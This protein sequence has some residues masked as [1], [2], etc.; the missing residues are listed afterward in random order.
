MALTGA[1]ANG[2]SG[3]FLLARGRADGLARV[4]RDSAP[5]VGVER[6]AI[7]SFWAVA[8]SAPALVGMRLID[9]TASGTPAQPLH[10]L[11][12]DLLVFV[13]GWTGY[14][15]LSRAVVER[16]G[17]ARRWAGYLTVWNWCNVVQ[18]VLLLVGSLPV[19]FHAPEPVSQAAALVVLGWALWLEW[20]ATRL[21]L[22]LSGAAAA[23]L[24]MLDLSVGLLLAA[25]AG[26]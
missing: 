20:F 11:A 12:L 6:A 5:P 16:L 3:A 8:I 15:V 21:A 19:L 24:V 4:Q 22:D 2:L 18:Y 1:V 10:A 23:G 26:I 17:R 7:R 13:V 9:W 14:A 25:V